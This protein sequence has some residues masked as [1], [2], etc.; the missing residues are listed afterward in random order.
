MESSLD[1]STYNSDHMSS[2]DENNIDIITIIFH[3]YDMNFK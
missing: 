1:F 2:D 3:I